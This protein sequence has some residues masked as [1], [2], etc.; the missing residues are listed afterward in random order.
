MISLLA[1]KI[2]QRASENDITSSSL[3]RE[4]G[5]NQVVLTTYFHDNE[6]W[7]TCK[8]GETNMEKRGRKRNKRI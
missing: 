8:G 4:M 6:N 2:I 3:T 1:I 7:S 5:I